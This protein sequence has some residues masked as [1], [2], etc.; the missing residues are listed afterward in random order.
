MLA[1]AIRVAAAVPLLAGAAGMATG[2]AFLGEATGSAAD[3]HLRYLSGL[4]FGLGAAAVWCAADLPRRRGVFG[5]LSAMVVLGGLARALG[6]LVA[7]TPPW[8]HQAAL[9]ME[10]GVVPALWWASRRVAAG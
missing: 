4:L 1:A 2:G 3:S 8:P 6:L 9:L 5:V 7:G 10:L